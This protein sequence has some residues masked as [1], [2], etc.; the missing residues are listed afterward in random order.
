MPAGRDL[1]Q[2]ALALESDTSSTTAEMAAQAAARDAVI[3]RTS[4]LGILANVLLS[5]FKAFVGLW[6]HSIAIVMDAVNNLSDALSSVVTIA[7]TKLARREPNRK[8]PFGYGR[9]EYLSAM[10]IAVIVLYAGLTALVESVK[11]IVQPV[12]PDYSPAA[13]IIVGCAV[14][15]KVLLGRYVSNVGEKVRSDSLT[16]SGQ[17]ALM[18]AAI[19][20]TTLLTAIIYLIFDLSLEAWLSAAI[21]LYIIKS[22]LEMLLRTLSTILGE[23]VDASLARA[24]R[25]TILSHDGVQ[26]VYDMVIHNYGPDLLIGSLHIEVPE[27]LSADE[28][29]RLVRHLT[30]DVYREHHVMLNAIGI[31]SMN[32]KDPEALKALSQVR[33]IALSHDHVRQLHGFHIDQAEKAMRFDLV[34]S[35]EAE[36]RYG[37]YKHVCD[38]VREAFPGYAVQVTMDTDFIE[39]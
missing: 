3:F 36:D 30:T 34:I 5:A 24:I 9:F 20:A 6:S 38:E 10:V 7:G 13:L 17:D 28:L 22:G 35:L 27:T 12:T 14:A 25:D 23:A 11:K 8:H 26:G 1:Q 21:A 15:V 18:D 32:T 16:N 31:Y 2:N 19:S 39:G 33:K 4:L 37:I 29:D